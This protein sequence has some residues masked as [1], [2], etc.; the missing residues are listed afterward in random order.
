MVDGKIADCC[1]GRGIDEASLR[2]VG[3]GLL[4]S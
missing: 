3:V 4:L 1:A 2:A